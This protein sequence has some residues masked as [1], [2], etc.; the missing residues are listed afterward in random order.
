MIQFYPFVSLE[1]L[2]KESVGVVPRKKDVLD[3]IAHS[4]LF[5]SKIFGSNDR[6]IDKIQPKSVR[7]KFI[8][9]LFNKKF[10]IFKIIKYNLK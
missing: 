8:H 3:D 7:T 2:H 1:V 4:F 10:T 9:N 6:R 5:E